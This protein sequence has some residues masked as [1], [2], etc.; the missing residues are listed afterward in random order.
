MKYLSLN[1]IRNKCQ[2]L[3]VGEISREEISRWAKEFLDLDEEGGVVYRPKADE[4]L[5]WNLINYLE[6]IDM[7]GYE[8]KYLINDHDMKQFLCDQILDC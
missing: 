8:S 1:L 7:A 4:K 2:Q 6:A 5:L 3:F